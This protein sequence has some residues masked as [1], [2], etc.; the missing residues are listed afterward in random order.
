MK[1]INKIGG[2]CLKDETCYEKVKTLFS[3]MPGVLVASASF[4]TT[5]QLKAC[6]ESACL[7]KPYEA[8][9]DSLIDW[10]IT[11]IEKLK[12]DDNLKKQLV[13]D[14]AQIKT[15]L[16][17]VSLLGQFSESQH[18]WLLCFGEYWSSKIIAQLLDVSWIDVG[19][20]IT[21]NKHD[22]LLSVDW[23]ETKK[24]LSYALDE[25]R[26]S[27]IVVPGFVA[28][29][30]QGLRCLL[31]YNGSDFTAAILA[32]CLNADKLIKWTDVDGIYTANP[33]FVK[34]A[35][36]ISQLSYQEAS[37]LAYFGASVLHPQA[38]QPAIEEKI[39]IHIKNF[40]KPQHTGTIINA[41]KPN[42][43]HI[44]RGLS[45]IDSVSLINLEGT[46][47]VGVCGVAARLFKALSEARI[48]VILISQASS[49]H[50]ISFVVNA[51]QS[52]K[53][54]VVV[55]N[56]FNYELE[57]GVIQK[58]SIDDE[59]AI[60][61]AVG[62]GMQGK[63]GVAANY[64]KTLSKANINIL[65]IAQGSSER[66]ISTVIN[67]KDT[68]RA[69]RSLH[70]G[71]YLA[72]KTL[73]IGLIGPGGVGKK[74]LEQISQ[75][76]VR[77][78]ES[79]HVDLRVRGIM[80]SRHM[81][82][83][84]QSLDLD[85]W[86]Q[87]TKKKTKPDFNAF[88]NHIKTPELPHALIIDCTSSESI[89]EN[90]LSIGEQ[91]CHLITPNKKANSAPLGFYHDLFAMTKTHHCHYLYETTVCA[92]LPVIKTIQDLIATGDTITH[93]EGIVSGTLA[94]IF[95]Q[96]A[97]G[98]SFAQ[99]VSSAY[100]LG[101]T[102]PDP[103]DDLN[104]LDVA[105]KF[106]CL[107]RELNYECELSDVKLLNM[108]PKALSDC[109]VETFLQSIGSHQEEIETLIKK[110][111]KNKTAL[112]YV[113]IIEEGKITIELN[114]YDSSHPFANT[115]GTDNIVLIKSRR[116]DK[117]PLII[118]GPGAGVDVTAAGVFAD[119]LKLVS[120]L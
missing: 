118:Q 37:E 103:R 14:K 73:S 34:S 92:G 52:E 12:L 11:L 76:L 109:S 83:S 43:S 108:V 102:E 63:L 66:N 71:F 80:S 58:V 62:D 94:Y 70:G 87:V 44:V 95:N 98:N 48:S 1:I 13:D 64:F 31:G 116:Y 41:E 17:S 6:L 61:A 33:K 53:A 99:S 111:L 32:K 60:V 90:Y 4:G 105:R 27:I 115:A 101:Y 75:N 49:E 82:L 35:F 9:L 119:L 79:F 3:S 97:Q 20:I 25:K 68:Q 107:A 55:K 88:L 22:A 93:I 10:H 29:D 110:K 104:G 59:C 19:D 28:Q 57:N 46:G 30:A 106:V 7:D 23:T 51:I 2:S 18:D 65:A 8:S 39:S 91:G 21:V 42:D 113:G 84:E 96:C 26:K 36:A 85:R 24:R 74:L 40:F 81:L 69:L 16:Q 15:L 77:L 50:S 54:R 47:L 120:M 100:E 45:S 78:K 89:T 56:E 117:Q 67:A 112:A 5:N 114:A 86:Q 38:V 72:N